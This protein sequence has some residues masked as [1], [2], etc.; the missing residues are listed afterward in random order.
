MN[1]DQNH[2]DNHLTAQQM[3][4]YL[5]GNLSDVE[6]HKFEKHM[7]ECDFCAEAM[8]GLEAMVDA[9]TFEQDVLKLKKRIEIRTQVAKKEPVFLYKRVLRIAAMVALLVVVSVL[10]TNYFK[11]N[12][13]Q[14]EYSERKKTELPKEKK[15]SEKGIE[16]QAELSSDSTLKPTV[17]KSPKGVQESTKPEIVKEEPEIEEKIN[18]ADNNKQA[19]TIDPVTEDEMVRMD[20]VVVSE[21]EIISAEVAEEDL[22]SVES[23]EVE[24][25]MVMGMEADNEAMPASTRER[26][27]YTAAGAEAKS[28][29]KKNVSKTEIIQPQPMDNNAFQ[30]YLKD[31]LRYPEAA[32]DAKIKG[33]VTLQFTVGSTGDISQIEVIKG[34]GYGCDE[35]AIR[36]LRDGPEWIPGSEDNQPMEMEAELKVKFKSL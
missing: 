9:T 20:E 17:E 18:L 8:E 14:K 21:E 26:S 12:L 33:I 19:K 5:S 34:L 27:M 31:S 4:D 28:A 13:E 30:Q 25:A 15:A 1:S 6:M 16:K 10:I 22:A 29:Q 24:E 23:L 36:L 2:S 32:L 35:E 3:Q 11:S 7:L